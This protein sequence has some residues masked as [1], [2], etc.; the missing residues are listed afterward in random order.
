MPFEYVFGSPG[1]PSGIAG[2]INIEAI[3]LF[4][5][6]TSAIIA[7]VV[8]FSFVGWLV[9]QRLQDSIMKRAV[10]L[11]DELVLLCIFAYFGY[12]LLFFLYLRA[13]SL[14]PH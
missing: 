11:V 13:R 2:W 8:L 12:E 6:H 14:G 7:A 1:E 3:Q 9:R 10:L 4:T 5:H